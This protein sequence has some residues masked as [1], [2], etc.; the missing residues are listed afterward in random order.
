MSL[1]PL[2]PSLFGNTKPRIFEVM[3]LDHAALLLCGNWAV[4][5]ESHLI[6]YVRKPD[7]TKSAEYMARYREILGALTSWC[8]SK[9]RPEVIMGDNATITRA[10]LEAFCL[11][12]GGAVPAP[13]RWP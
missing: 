1:P 8:N 9:E 11:E 7:C 2:T 5:S 12:I 3:T 10:G 6:S 13:L 4:Y